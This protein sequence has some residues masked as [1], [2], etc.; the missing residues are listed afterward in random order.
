MYIRTI[1]MLCKM[2]YGRG[3]RQ[4]FRLP[5]YTEIPQNLVK[6]LL[7]KRNASYF[8]PSFEPN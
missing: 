1:D 4:I 3:V 7:Q 6:L 2:L 8:K 5:K